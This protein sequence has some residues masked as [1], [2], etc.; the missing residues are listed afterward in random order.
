MTAI[1]EPLLTILVM[2]LL[3][4]L[5]GIVCA[6][7][8]NAR[9]KRGSGSRGDR[10]RDPARARLVVSQRVPSV[11]ETVKKTRDRLHGRGP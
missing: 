2:F 7:S 4:F 10:Y 11:S 1:P 6:V 9:S 8:I 5:A 3:I